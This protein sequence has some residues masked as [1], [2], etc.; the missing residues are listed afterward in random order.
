[1]CT[2]TVLASIAWASTI[3]FEM[4]GTVVNVVHISNSE[5]HW[6]TGKSCVFMMILG[7]G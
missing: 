3:I 7:P 5:I 2:S 1:M 4:A 6:V